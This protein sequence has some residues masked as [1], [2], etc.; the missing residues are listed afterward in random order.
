MQCTYTCSRM[1]SVHV[2]NFIWSNNVI[3]V[4]FYHSHFNATLITVTLRIICV[5]MSDGIQQQKTYT[6][7]FMSF[8]MFGA[9]TERVLS[10]IT[11]LT[12]EMV[13]IHVSASFM[14]ILQYSIK[15]IER[16]L[17]FQF[18]QRIFWFNLK[19]ICTIL[20]LIFNLNFRSVF[21]LCDFLLVIFSF[22][23]NLNSGSQKCNSESNRKWN[24]FLFTLCVF[25]CCV[26]IWH[27]QQK[28]NHENHKY[29]FFLF[30]FLLLDES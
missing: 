12:F 25:V 4:N 9:M 29:F 3:K 17:R 22:M 7:L 8:D 24:C 26:V 30:L 23:G 15:S 6:L 13:V 11:T 19:T 14:Q 20:N 18:I 10:W 16:N 28:P 21:F 2:L 1:I 27:Q 5:M